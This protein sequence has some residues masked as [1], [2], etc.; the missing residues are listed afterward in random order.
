MFLT[1]AADFSALFSCS[2]SCSYAAKLSACLSGPK[3]TDGHRKTG[4]FV[5][6][7][8]NAGKHWFAANSVEEFKK[9]GEYRDNHK[10]IDFCLQLL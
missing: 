1:A 4:C 10:T 3:M 5:S 9:L 7:T 6:L 2:Y 8:L